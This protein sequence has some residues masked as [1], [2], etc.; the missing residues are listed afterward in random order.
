M[1]S[2]YHKKLENIS[3]DVQMFQKDVDNKKT[4]V[5]FA[6]STRINKVNENIEQLKINNTAELCN[7]AKHMSSQQEALNDETKILNQCLAV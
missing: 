4:D 5:H 1:T 2:S 3:D 6:L 7:N